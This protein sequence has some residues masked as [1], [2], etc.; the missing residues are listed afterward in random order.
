VEARVREGT[1]DD[2][3]LLSNRRCCGEQSVHHT[4]W[5]KQN[6]IQAFTMVLPT[7]FATFSMKMKG[8]PH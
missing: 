8:Q 7:M 4:A 5:F 3:K 6:T 1:K 2:R